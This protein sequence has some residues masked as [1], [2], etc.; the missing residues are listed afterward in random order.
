[1][2]KHNLAEYVWNLFRASKKLIK[3][4]MQSQENGIPQ[5]LVFCSTEFSLKFQG[6]NQN[7]IKMTQIVQE[8]W[9]GTHFWGGNQ[10]WCSFLWLMGFDIW[11]PAFLYEGH[12]QLGIP[13]HTDNCG[14]SGWSEAGWSCHPLESRMF[15]M[16][17]WC[18]SRQIMVNN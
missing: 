12:V 14:M 7:M 2:K 1:M 15:R 5:G 16:L 17:V 10:T 4:L 8:S 6:N 11:P 9:I 18:F 3:H 13:R